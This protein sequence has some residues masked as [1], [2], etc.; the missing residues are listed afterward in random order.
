MQIE[1]KKIVLI[2]IFF[3]VAVLLG[4]L[5]YSFFFRSEEGPY[6]IIDGKKVPVGQLPE[7][8][9]GLP[10]GIVIDPETGLPVITDVTAP[11]STGA[12]IEQ[13]TEPDDVAKGGRTKVE[14]L[15]K[16]DVVNLYPNNKG[17]LRFYDKESGRFF[18]L[19]DKGEFELM[20]DDVFYNV[21][22]VTWDKSGNQAILEYPDGSNI[23]YNFATKQ[24]VTLPK[25]MTDFAFSYT[26]SNI[27]FEWYNEYDEEDNWLG[28]ATPDGSEIKFVEPMADKGDKVT[29]EFSPDGRYIAFFEKSEGLD[30]V[31]VVPIGANGENFKSFEVLG[32]GFESQWTPDNKHLLYSIHSERTGRRPELWITDLYGNQVGTNNRPLSV[33]TWAHKCTFGSSATDLYCAVPQD[34]PEGIGWFP[35]QASDYPD[36]FYYIN[37]ETGRQTLLA[38]PEG[39]RPHYSAKQIVISEDGSKLYFLDE[40]TND[41]Y[42]INLK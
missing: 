2:I 35:E 17:Q 34:L 40:L 10:P 1:R 26:N 13:K 23:F 9:E 24:Q 30:R 31:D 18:R 28:V 38:L 33:Q 32:R 12:L 6:V 14:R 29:P 7:I 20:S 22:S 4:W 39:S 27:A 15:G 21:E 42:T 11:T 37:L 36:N 41:I 16:G 19:N 8:A 3:G 5:I 25:Q